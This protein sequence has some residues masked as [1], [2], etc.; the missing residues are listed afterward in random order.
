M[1]LYMYIVEMIFLENSKWHYMCNCLVNIDYIFP[2]HATYI[3]KTY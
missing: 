3:L 2:K 1:Y